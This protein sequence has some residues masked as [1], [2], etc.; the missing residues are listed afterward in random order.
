[1]KKSW[2]FD[3]P[4][5]FCFSSPSPSFLRLSLFLF[6]MLP[7]PTC[8]CSASMPPQLF[9]MTKR[10]STA[11]DWPSPRALRMNPPDVDMPMA[12]PNS[13]TSP[14]VSTPSPLPPSQPASSHIHPPFQHHQS[15]QLPLNL[16]LGG[17][18]QQAGH[19]TVFQVVT[20]HNHRY[21]DRGGNRFIRV[22]KNQN[23]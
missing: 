13:Y 21:V 23:P 15:L 17:Y 10:D 5:F 7:A 19:T 16:R 20:Q 2:P 3:V 18:C 11:A 6:I 9:V 12:E 22:S 4:V 8:L 14:S 1:M